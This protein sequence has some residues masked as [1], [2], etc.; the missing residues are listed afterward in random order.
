ME[1]L[2]VTCLVTAGDSLGEGCLWDEKAQCLWWLDIAR[3]SRIHRLDPATGAHRMWHT[4]LTVTALAL[5]KTG[6]LL[7]AGE[8]GLYCFDT[9]TGA[10]SAFSRPETD[11]PGNRS[12]D[13]ACDPQGRFWLGTMHQNI[14]PKGEDLPIPADTGALY[15]VDGTGAASKREDHVGVSNGPCWSPDGR[16]FYF[17]DSKN[18]VIYAYDFDGKAGA[19][20]NRRVLNDSKDHGYPDGATVD[21]EGFVWSA[22]WEGACVLRIDPRGRIDRVIAMPAQRPTCVCFGGANL[23]TMYVT[24]SRAHLD[25]SSM[26]RYPLQGGLFCFHPGVRGTPKFSFA[27]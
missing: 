17:S 27:G 21:A 15:C 1:I 19:I 24:S 12:N 2:P 10:I 22:R 14:G 9:V 26:A 8:D 18:Q 20:S 16:T 25:A 11:R 3:P 6:G 4:S 5:R 13:G 23:D 7:L